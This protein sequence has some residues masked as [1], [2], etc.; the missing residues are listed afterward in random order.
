MRNQELRAKIG[1]RKEIT[2]CGTAGQ[3]DNISMVVAGPYIA[4]SHE[5]RNAAKSHPQPYESSSIT[6]VLLKYCHFSSTI[7]STIIL[8]CCILKHSVDALLPYEDLLG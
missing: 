3:L 7:A 8:S 1:G 5:S 2:R 6:K 4:G